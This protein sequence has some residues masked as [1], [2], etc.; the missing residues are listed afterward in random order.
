MGWVAEP[1]YVLA[2]VSSTSVATDERDV[3]GSRC[4]IRGCQLAAGTDQQE[5]NNTNAK[6]P[7]PAS[8][9]GRE[10]GR[11]GVLHQPVPR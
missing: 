5:R 1:A 2:L 9:P 8:P 11:L 6:H 3:S 7:T 4:A 10:E